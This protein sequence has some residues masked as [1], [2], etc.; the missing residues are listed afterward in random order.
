MD[1]EVYLCFPHV[2]IGSLMEVA[3]SN[4]VKQSTKN[5]RKMATRMVTLLLP[6]TRRMSKSIAV[7]AVFLS[8]AGHNVIR[9]SVANG[10]ME[11]EWPRCTNLATRG[12]VIKSF[13]F[14]AVVTTNGPWERNLEPYVVNIYEFAI[15]DTNVPA[16]SFKVAFRYG[17]CLFPTGGVFPLLTNLRAGERYR[18]RVDATDV[19][20]MG[21][22]KGLLI[23]ELKDISKLNTTTD[24]KRNGSS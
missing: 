10:Q 12:W 14:S 24:R 5:G 23:G 1:T 4:V 15:T 6:N 13:E 20:S 16:K 7:G 11:A 8:L 17:G 18:L 19:G 2:R 9:L 3:R 22:Q 21:D